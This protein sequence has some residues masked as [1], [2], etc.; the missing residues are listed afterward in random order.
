MLIFVICKQTSENYWIME[1]A[2]GVLGNYALVSE[3]LPL[4]NYVCSVPDIDTEK[5]M[6]DPFSSA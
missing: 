6:F 4:L 3:Y 2:Q 1:I 5:K